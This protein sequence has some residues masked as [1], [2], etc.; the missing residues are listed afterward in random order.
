VPEA[1][2]QTL[3]VERGDSGVTLLTLNRPSSANTISAQLSRELFDCLQLLRRDPE[4]RAL[5]VTGAGRHFCAGA[6]L[7]DPE[8][9]IPGWQDLGRRAVDGLAAMEVPVIAAI[10]GTAFGGGLE[11]ALACDIRIAETG[12]K[13]GLPEIKFGALPG[14]GGL[15]RLQAVIGASAAMTL[16]MSGRS[17]FANEGERLGLVTLASTEASAVETAVALAEELSQMASY[18]TRTAK[19]VFRQTLGHAPDAVMA[20]EYG[21][22]DRMATPEEKRAEELRA[23]RRDPV[24]ER[25][26]AESPVAAV[27]ESKLGPGVE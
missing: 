13:L 22:I 9:D 27:T 11:L 5:V 15:S 16:V 20:V 1:E 2:F 19:L 6:D 8:R 7:R 4:V 14:A 24:Y 10:N 12:A 23:A 26:F 3:R 18:A 21:L 17:I 25:I